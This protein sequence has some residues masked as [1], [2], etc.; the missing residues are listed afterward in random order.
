[1]KDNKLI[2]KPNNLFQQ[3]GISLV[4]LLHLLPWSMEVPHL[5]TSCQ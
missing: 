3:K 2:A 4:L 1:M 5:A